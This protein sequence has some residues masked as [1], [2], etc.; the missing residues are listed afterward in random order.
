MSLEACLLHLPAHH[1]NII[2]TDSKG[3]PIGHC[4][5]EQLA[6]VAEAR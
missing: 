4:A 5:R 2:V 3:K 6:A 1:E